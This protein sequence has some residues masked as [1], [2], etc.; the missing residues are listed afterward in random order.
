ML[1][2][3]NKLGTSPQISL[4]PKPDIGKKPDKN[5]YSLKV[6]INNYSGG[7]GGGGNSEMLSLYAPIL[8][9]CSSKTLLKFLVLL[10]K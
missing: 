6:D 7:G 5:Q 2:D 8:N 4:K 1:Q 10:N 9:I 3:I